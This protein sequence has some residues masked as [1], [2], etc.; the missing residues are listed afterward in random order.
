MH[1]EAHNNSDLGITSVGHQYFLDKTM[2]LD[3]SAITF[4]AKT[5]IT[6]AGGKGMMETWF[7]KLFL[8]G[9]LVLLI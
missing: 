1:K 2:V 5:W 6:A 3:V 7:L 9:I 4:H 8:S